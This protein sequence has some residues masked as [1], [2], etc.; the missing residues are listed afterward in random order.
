MREFLSYAV[1][2]MFGRY[3]L[4]HAGL[5]LANQGDGIAE[6]RAQVPKPKFA[7]NGDNIIPLL[8]RDWVDGDAATRFHA[9]LRITFG[10]ERFEENLAFVETAIGKDVRK[11]FLRDFFADHLKRHKKRPIYWLFSSGSERAFQALVYLHRYDAS[12]LARMRTEY[13]LPLQGRMIA[14]IEQIEADKLKA[15]S[16][17]LASALRH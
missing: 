3:S 6:Y 10:D 17:R 5:I 2:C 11:F 12:T 16:T 7:P 8:D 13:V 14:R 9:F 4:D 1:G 15:T